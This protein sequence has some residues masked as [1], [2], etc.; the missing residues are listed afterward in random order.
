M[1]SFGMQT[2]TE[3]KVCTG[4]NVNKESKTGVLEMNGKHQAYKVIWQ[5]QYM[6]I[7]EVKLD[8]RKVAI[9]KIL[10]HVM[11]LEQGSLSVQQQ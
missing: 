7:V 9:K 3:Y 11:L 4:K 8:T 2:G 6:C 1:K 10:I 5:K